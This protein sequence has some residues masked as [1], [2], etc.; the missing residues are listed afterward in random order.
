MPLEDQHQHSNP[1]AADSDDAR[2][3]DF[4]RVRSQKRAVLAHQEHGWSGGNPPSIAQLFELW[5]VDPQSDP[6]AASLIAEDFLRRKWSGEEPSLDAYQRDYP[7]H[8]E[9]CLGLMVS[10]SLATASLRPG[11]LLS[12]PQPG[13]SVFGFRLRDQIGRGTFAR[14]FLATQADLAERPVVLKISAIEGD[15]PQTLAQLQHTNIVPIYSVHEDKQAGLRVV[16]MP[17]FGGANLTSVLEQI[18]EKTSTP[19]KG[20]ELV[21][22]LLEV[23]TQSTRGSSSGSSD[24]DDQ[25]STGTSRTSPG[26][27]LDPLDRLRRMTFFETAAWI[28][29]QLADGLQHAHHRG[30][31][32]RDIKPSNVL[33]SDEGQPL[34]LDFNL[35]HDQ[36]VPAEAASVGGTI[37]YMAPEHLRAMIGKAPAEAVDRRSDVYSLGMVL[38]EILIGDN[39]FG[40]SA[41][42]SVVT[43]QIEAIAEER[44][45]NAPSPRSYRPDIPWTLESILRKCLAPAPADRYQ[46]AEHLAEDLRRFL[47]DRNLKYAPELSRAEQARKFV[48]RHPRLAS[49]APVSLA[50]LIVVVCL[51]G[52]LLGAGKHLARAK[53]QLSLAAAKERRQAH[54]EGVVQAHCLANT[55]AGPIDNL[56]EGISVCERTLA[57][58][59]TPGEPGRD[60]PD[61]AYFAPEER[62]R[63]AEDQRELYLLLAGARVRQAHGQP[64]VVRQALD[65]VER[66]EAVGGLPPTRALWEDRAR[67]LALIGEREESQA[68]LRRA[69]R[70]PATSAR[71]HYLL[72]TSWARRGTREDFSRAIAELDRALELDPRDY[73]STVQ[74]GICE[75]ELGN[76][77]AAAG[78]FGK[79]IGLWPEFAW[80][81]FNR[82]CV[83]D[84]D[85]KKREAVHDY[86]AALARDPN[87]TPAYLNR[88][89]ACLELRRFDQAL[90]DF[91][92][93]IELGH[94]SPAAVAGRG[95]AL[96]ALGRHSEADSAFEEALAH[97]ETLNGPGRLRILWTYGFAVSQRLPQK[98]RQVFDAILRTSPRHPEALY[99]RAMLAAADGHPADAVRDLG[100]A[101]DANPDMSL[102]RQYRAIMLARLGE[103]QRAAEDIQRCL[104]R[105][106]ADGS[107]YYAA[108][109]V[110]SLASRQRADPRLAQQAVE[111]LDLA[112]RAGLD[113]TKAQTDP[114]LDPIRELPGF[115]RLVPSPVPVSKDKLSWQAR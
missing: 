106:P 100:L 19:R 31:L 94:D 4:A 37:A 89:L 68:A 11:R 61:W 5:P 69:E 9:S 99:G 18:R 24:P 77:V 111:F 41:G 17:F 86:S 71:D 44:S 113:I 28:V 20:A 97:A 105:N 15:E 10:R 50:S 114:D 39:P 30:I 26:D 87:L 23:R 13:D 79:C 91:D 8:K 108:A 81:Y 78:E 32:H 42:Y 47:D 76:R 93:A 72:A 55:T 64:E 80:G 101:L 63:L 12:L 115:Q 7:E 103:W 53:G 84:R 98:A 6:D 33:I 58:Y 65:L 38:G 40:E 2:Q 36:T 88:G 48:R 45:K 51:W 85:G 96:E 67:Y 27:G 74:R 110:A 82:G 109:C 95:M 104:Q 21:D 107:A 112:G 29:A 92:R 83:L 59:E 57:L 34:L 46:Q 35:A 14:V 22:A 54:E 52:M 70:I 66:A 102:A 43:W 75:L 90:A 3:E 25:S 16:C 49:A 60:H 56:P 1:S 62:R 73:W